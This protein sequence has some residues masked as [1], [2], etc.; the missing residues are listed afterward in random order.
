MVFL[1]TTPATGANDTKFAYRTGAPDAAGETDGNHEDP[2]DP[3]APGY[4]N[5]WLRVVRSGNVFSAHISA[6]GVAWTQIASQ[7]AGAGN[8]LSGGGAFRED[9]LV[10]LAVSRHSGAATA[11][12]VFKDFKFKE[13]FAFAVE[14]NKDFFELLVYDCEFLEE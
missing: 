8:W 1:R 13:S 12:A 7:D 11:T 3:N 2:A 10:G 5:A 6:D 4:P 9:A 14:L